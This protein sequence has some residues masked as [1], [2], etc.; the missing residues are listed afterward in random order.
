LSQGLLWVD[1]TVVR[2]IVIVAVLAVAGAVALVS[3]RSRSHHP[4]ISVAGLDFRPGVVVFTSTDCPRCREVLDVIKTV[5]VP[6]REVTYELEG[7][8]Q[9]RAGVIGVPLTVVIS[10]S[11]EVTAQLPGRI[12]RRALRNAAARAGL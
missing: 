10:H 1:N 12:S 2:V 6:V 9:R 5:D 4:P 7:E 3:R 11:G 8:L